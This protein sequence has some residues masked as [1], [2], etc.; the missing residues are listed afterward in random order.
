M[1][2]QLDSKWEGQFTEYFSNGNIYRG[3]IINYNRNGFGV[4]KWKSGAVFSGLWKDDQINQSAEIQLNE[5]VT[6]KVYK[7]EGQA[8]FKTYLFKK[9]RLV[10]Q[11]ELDIEGEPEVVLVLDVNSQAIPD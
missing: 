10:S 8:E 5:T 7:P 3:Q 1:G 4:F 6:L 11:V 9:D 2:E